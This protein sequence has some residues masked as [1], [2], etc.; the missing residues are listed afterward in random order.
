MEIPRFG[1]AASVPVSRCN[2][3]CFPVQVGPADLPH[4]HRSLPPSRRAGCLLLPA[5]ALPASFEAYG[6]F[7][8]SVLYFYFF[9]DL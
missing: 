7:G 9:Y 3:G 8:S 6:L 1:V 4:D 5:F 2:R